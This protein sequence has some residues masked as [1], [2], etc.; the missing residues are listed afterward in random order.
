M[1]ARGT[2]SPHSR[3][4]GTTAAGT[5]WTTWN[6]V[7]ANAEAVR[8]AAVPT[9]ASRSAMAKKPH[10]EPSTSTPSYATHTPTVISVCTNERSANANA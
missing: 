5:N 6:S 1:S 2:V 3:N 10:S 9:R 8:P 7:R 4:W